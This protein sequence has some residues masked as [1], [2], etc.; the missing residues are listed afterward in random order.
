MKRHLLAL[1]SSLAL[2]SVSTVRAEETPEDRLAALG[3]TLPEVSPSIANYVGV[4]QTGNLLFLSGHIPRDAEGAFL[5]GRLGGNMDVEAGYEAARLAGIALL[6]TLKDHLGELDRVK[7]V[8]KVFGMV[9]AT[10]EFTS[11]SQV[12]NGCSD[13]MVKVFGEKGRHARA[14]SGFSSL[15][16]GACVEIEM[17]VE[18]E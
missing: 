3:I 9:S 2:F 18:V 16:V 13:L 11:H 12:I 4:V 5:T 14:A 6:A 7:R 1:L 15:P 17:I 8:V 10:P